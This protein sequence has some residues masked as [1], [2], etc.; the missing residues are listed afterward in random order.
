[1]IKIA[2]IDDDKK[3]LE[4]VYNNVKIILQNED[5][6]IAL[7]LDGES[8]IEQV[9]QE[10]K[11]DILLC[12]IELNGMNGVEVGKFVRASCP[13]IYLIYLTSHSEFALDG[14]KLDAYQYIMK[15]ELDTRFSK[16]LFDLVEK[17]KKNKKKF[18][19]VGGNIDKG[20]LNFE[21]IICVVK[22]KS[23]KYIRFQTKYGTYRERKTLESV[24]KELNSEEFILVERGIIVNMKHVVR[25]KGNTIFLDNDEQ[26]IVSGA[27]MANVK[28]EISD[29][30]RKW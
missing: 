14:Y 4:T 25:L 5:I 15:S 22:E 29:F 16:I 6:E 10:K 3:M 11:V 17:I 2:I 28:K 13:D 19:V 8:F 30:W 24:M 26:I 12:D 1:M 7:F 18:R 21:D 27:R 9:E 20:V 23:A